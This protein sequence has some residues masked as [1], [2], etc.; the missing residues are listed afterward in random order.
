MVS[1]TDPCAC[2]VLQ[3]AQML[4][5]HLQR[6]QLMAATA[7]QLHLLQQRMRDLH[8]AAMHGASPQQ[9]PPVWKVH[10]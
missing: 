5:L 7:Q 10:I 8:M 3:Q 9:A 4:E 1:A 6:R 2:P